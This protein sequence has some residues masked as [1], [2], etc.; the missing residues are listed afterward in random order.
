MNEI[1]TKAKLTFLIVIII[2]LVGQLNAQP[3]KNKH[4]IKKQFSI[5]RKIQRTNTDT[6]G[7][8]L[9]G[10]FAPEFAATGNIFIYGYMGGGYVYGSNVDSLNVCAQGYMNT[11]NS[12][13][14]IN[15]I[16]F[17][18]GGKYE[19]P[20]D[21]VD[22]TIGVNIYQMSANQA[23]TFDGTN[24][25]ASHEGPAGNALASEVLNISA[26]DT[27]GGL[28]SVMLSSSI[29]V[30]G[31]FAIEFDA[32]T[33]ISTG[34]T[35]GILSDENGSGWEYAF[36][37]F[38]PGGPF[39]VTNSAFGGNLNNNIAMFAVIGDN[40]LGI[41]SD[42][43]FNGLQVSAFPNPATDYLNVQYRLEYPSSSVNL[44]I[45]DQTGKI[46][47]TDISYQN[48]NGL[49]EFNINATS[50]ANGKYYL[51]IETDHSRITKSFIIYK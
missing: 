3:F 29:Y 39:M 13:A 16:L 44:S 10:N 22:G 21:N 32:S 46:V 47:Y 26:C 48:G 27:A 50:F 18:V 23:F 4:Y 1:T 5:D 51:N 2:S 33:F 14:E 43:F 12:T 30:T 24:W 40:N 45:F 20:N 8:T 34:D 9:S 38:T 11:N 7:W 25:N 42:E 49:R 41:D 31:N 19:N 36:H 37:N 28:T 6:A 17:Y 15:E 35:I